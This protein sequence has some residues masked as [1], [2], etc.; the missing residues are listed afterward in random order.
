MPIEDLDNWQDPKMEK[1]AL[2][3]RMKKKQLKKG[4]KINLDKYVRIK[5]M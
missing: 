4:K 2:T 5:K 3:I 1:E